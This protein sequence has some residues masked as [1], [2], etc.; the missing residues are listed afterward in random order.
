[1]HQGK[2][3]KQT[4]V[5]GK[6]VFVFL[7]MTWSSV[8]IPAVCQTTL[9]PFASYLSQVKQN[10][11][12]FKKAN[13]YPAM[14]DAQLLAA[15]GAFDPQLNYEKTA[16]RLSGTN[17]YQYDDGGVVANTN[18]PLKFKAG[19]EKS[20]GIYIDP[21]RTDGVASYLGVS[22]P[23]LQGLITDKKRTELAKARIGLNLN[24]AERDILV[25]ETLLDAYNAYTD[26][27]AMYLQK[28]TVDSF[29]QISLNRIQLTR[30]LFD[31]GD[32]SRA[33]T[34]E[35]YT[36]YQSY[37]IAAAEAAQAYVKATLQLANFLWSDDREPVLPA[38][39]VYPDTA[40]L[41]A[42]VLPPGFADD[43]VALSLQ[44]PS[45]SYYNFKI[46]QKVAE[47]RLAFQNI[48]PVL[49]VQANILSKE[50]FRFKG[51]NN[52]YLNNNYK[53][54]INFAFPI[55]MREGRGKLRS[56]KLE[57]SALEFDMQN[58]RRILENKMLTYRNA[59]ANIAE[60]LNLNQLQQQQFNYLLGIELLRFREGESSLFLINSRETKLL[61]ARQKSIDL[62]NKFQKS[63]NEFAFAGGTIQDY[64]IN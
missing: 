26:W 20:T 21:Q 33:D 23:L 9:L 27:A 46:R 4:I 5:A 30:V 22:L 38:P 51:V 18:S 3:N 11:P 57:I 44:N 40:I 55:F 63:L 35:A 19:Y 2:R 64:I 43:A 1:M 34:V 45:V 49:D 7:W 29:V 6:I 50:Y 52:L 58:K 32:R 53:F 14:A 36:Q 28:V 12:L 41:S 24:A 15:R 8:C 54:G 60:Q 47:R 62:A 25:N 48:L 61:E 17:Y 10:H 42:R 59:A 39:G 16:K 31:G 37:K 13:L 56:V